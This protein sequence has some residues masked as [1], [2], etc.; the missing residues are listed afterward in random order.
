MPTLEQ[1][2]EEFPDTRF[3]VDLKSAA[4]VP[5]L[6]SFI[7]ARA[8]QDRVL[9]GSF[10]PARMREFRRLSGGRVATSATPPEVAAFLALP[11]RA[12]ARVAGGFD[13]L[14]IPRRRGRLPVTTPG[15]LRRAHAARKHVH[16]WTVDDPA[17]MAE[18]L[19]LG[20]DGLFTDRTDVLRD[21]LAR[22]GQWQEAA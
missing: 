2:F 3:N 18:L 8:A 1:L 19:E 20:V 22:R 13:A 16:V 6:A 14:Q 10:S 5:Q 15:L 11:H 7:A 9:V 21:V 17:E 4:A 12:A